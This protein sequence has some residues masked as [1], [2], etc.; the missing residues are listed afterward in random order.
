[1]V[2]VAGSMVVGGGCAPDV[3]SAPAVGEPA[4]GCYDQ[5][6]G[7]VGSDVWYSG[8]PSEF[9]NLTFWSSTDGSCSG[10][11][12]PADAAATTLIVTSSAANAEFLCRNLLGR[13]KVEGR[14][15]TTAG[16][17]SPGFGTGAYRCA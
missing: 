10:A 11:V 12:V 7:G 1:M 14:F 2:M 5:V 3:G 6:G 4:R 13:S 17:W 9:G 8:E 16:P 15:D